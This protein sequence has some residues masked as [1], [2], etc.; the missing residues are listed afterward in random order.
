MKQI[1]KQA[2]M[3]YEM[4]FW[5][6]NGN[7][8]AQFWKHSSTSFRNGKAPLTGHYKAFP[9]AP[10]LPLKETSCHDLK[11]CWTCNPAKIKPTLKYIFWLREITLKEE[12]LS[13]P[14]STVCIPIRHAW[15]LTILN[16]LAADKVLLRKINKS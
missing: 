14:T 16:H 2:C 13:S 10:N 4:S 5:N 6:M 1:N 11:H 3:I 7:K 8:D 12:I 9:I 15:T